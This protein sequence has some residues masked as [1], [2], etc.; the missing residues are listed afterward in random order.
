MNQLLFSRLNLLLL[1]V[2]ALVTIGGYALIPPGTQLPVHWDI[3]GQPD[4][5][6]PREQA[7]LIMPLLIAVVGL[8][9]WG[10]GRFSPPAQLEA[11]RFAWRTVV[12][13]VFGLFLI[14]QTCMV[15]IGMGYP[16]VTVRLICGSLGVMLVLLGNIMPK[17]QPNGL[18]G[19]RLP[20]LHDPAVWRKTQ[21]VGGLLFV[22]D[23]LILLVASLLLAEATLL[24]AVIGIALII[25]LAVTT[26]YSYRL[27][28]RQS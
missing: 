25:P 24:L 1:G 2:L 15:L 14:I 20:W 3:S 21:R 19:I 5:F 13:S 4:S 8:I 18:A 10:V 11:G 9:F 6:L 7:L 23:G 12:P 26:I 27:T 28:H 22:A 16:D 17:T